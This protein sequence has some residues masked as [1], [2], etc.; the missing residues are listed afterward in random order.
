MRYG[1]YEWIIIP[2][3]LNNSPTAFIHTMSNLFSDILDSGMVVFL[4]NIFIY[5]CTMKEHY[6]LK[7]LAHLHQC[8]LYCNLF[9]KK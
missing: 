1:L 7:V 8:I 2:K 5:S 6:I 4:D 3:G 9:K